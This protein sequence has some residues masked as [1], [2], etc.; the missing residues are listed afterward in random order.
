MKTKEEIEELAEKMFNDIDKP[1]RSGKDKHSYLV[2]VQEGYNQCQEDMKPLLKD[3]FDLWERL[4]EVGDLS[5]GLNFNK[6]YDEL[7]KS[8]NNEN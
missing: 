6:K 3:L 8:L 1:T 5:I 2:G 4:A 7:K